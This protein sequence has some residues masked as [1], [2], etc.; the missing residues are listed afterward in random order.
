VLRELFVEPATA[1]PRRRVE[2]R[3]RLRTLRCQGRIG[4]LDFP[5]IDRAA[6]P[7]RA[8]LAAIPAAQDEP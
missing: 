8:L 7:K 2:F 4:E 3:L 6:D 5:R 1:G